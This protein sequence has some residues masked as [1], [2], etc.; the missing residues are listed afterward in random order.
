MR[1][2]KADGLWEDVQASEG[3]KPLPAALAQTWQPRALA[4]DAD[5][6]LWLQAGEKG[7]IWRRSS[8]GDWAE[9]APAG[10]VVT[11]LVALQPGR[12]LALGG[13]MAYEL[14]AGRVEASAWAAVLPAKALVASDGRGTL[15]WVEDGVFPGAWKLQQASAPG[16][17]AQSLL[18][19]L[20]VSQGGGYT[21]LCSGSP[22]QL[23]ALK[24]QPVAL[25]LNAGKAYVLSTKGI[26][27]VPL[28][29]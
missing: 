19:S 20:P 26:L 13:G 2:T 7:A 27:Q 14:Q 28:K 11:R 16:A 9:Q 8:A 4:F 5:G 25:T 17:E 23:L 29:P 12:M 6:S 21:L 15:V 22:T 24:E 3:A 1:L 18:T 10:L